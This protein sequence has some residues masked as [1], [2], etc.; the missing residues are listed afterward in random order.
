M[1][2]SDR[3]SSRTTRNN[4]IGGNVIGSNIQTGDDGVTINGVHYPDGIPDNC[5]VINGQ[6]VPRRS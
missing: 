6:I 1:G 5:D 2:R 4:S 3:N